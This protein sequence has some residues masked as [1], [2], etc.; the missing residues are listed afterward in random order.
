MGRT[1]TAL[2][3]WFSC[4][5]LVPL[6]WA[7]PADTP[8]AEAE[9]DPV[10]APAT[11][12][13]LGDATAP[14]ISPRFELY[15]ASAHRV[16]SE[17][18][19]SHSGAFLRHL[20][21][22][23]LELGETSS[24]GLAREAIVGLYDQVR[25]WPDTAISAFTFAPDR[26]GRPRWAVRVDWPIG[27]VHDRVRSL[28]AA[29]PVRES[30]TG[31]SLAPREGGFVVA[32]DDA[33]IAYLLAAGPNRAMIVSHDHLP[34]PDRAI[35]GDS[36]DG[37]VK[38]LLAA[39]LHLAATEADSGATFFS[40]F[41]VVTAVDY[42]ATVTEGGDW[43]EVVEL[44]WPPISG[45]GGKALFSTVKQTFF[46]PREAFGAIAV[47]T[48]VMPGMIDALAG[49]GP[50]VVFE[51]GGDMAMIG[52]AAIGPVTKHA[53]AEV[54]ITVLP[55]TG[56]LPM[57]DI[58]FQV[59]TRHPEDFIKH[60][61]KSAQRSNEAFRDRARREPW[62]EISVRDHAAFW[63]ESSQQFGTMMMPLVMHPV[64]FTSRQTDAAGKDRDFAVIA[65]TSTSAEGFVRRWLDLP[66]PSGADEP[67]DA[68]PRF[69]PTQRK[70][71]GQAWINWN[72]VYNWVHPYL[73]VGLSFV[74]TSALLP[75]GEAVRD[76]LTHSIVTA[77]LHYFG[78]S[79]TH[80]GPLPFGVV[81]VPSFVATSLAPDDSGGSD[82]ARERLACQ[83]LR[84]LYHHSELFKKDLGRWPAEV[85]ELDGYVDFAGNPGLLRLRLSPKKQW[86]D[87]FEGLLGADD[88]ADEE[89]ADEDQRIDAE[90]FAIDWGR[91]TWSLGFAPGTFEH[92]DK[93]YIDHNG[94]IHRVEKPREKTPGRS[95][96][97]AKDTSETASPDAAADEAKEDE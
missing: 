34:V 49:F 78:L 52:E 42:A 66:R 73:D 69:L 11:D 58:V 51:E 59:R 60:V 6:T 86:S 3:A 82:L 79:L 56:F 33:P 54:C 31:V 97:P 35:V 4:A 47:H 27:D 85:Q 9:P 8:P 57:P 29:E 87:W 70:T 13:A 65:L 92:L 75:A 28:L 1:L 61:R 16:V 88:G 40:S 55:G 7:A 36:G 30:F 71:D 23:M 2:S 77:D 90:L 83:R 39:R 96:E 81:V 19:R 46:V 20:A 14:E 41:S 63:R 53:D 64:V 68:A 21:G 15:A 17:A 44:H 43:S 48:M 38:G 26:E 91:D 12:G 45:L 24:E 50:D 72:V 80:H 84:V 74:S 10:A 94:E 32:V 25:N 37:D 18:L 89:K 5:T 62:H 95:A 22:V 93:L 76:E 67:E